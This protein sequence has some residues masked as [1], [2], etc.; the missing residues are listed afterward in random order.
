MIAI[1]SSRKVQHNDVVW[2][3]I[4]DPK[5][6]QYTIDA[7]LLFCEQRPEGPSANLCALLDHSCVRWASVQSIEALVAHLES[8][9]PAFTLSGDIPCDASVFAHFTRCWL[10]IVRGSREPQTLCE[11]VIKQEF[12]IKRRRWPIQIMQPTHTE[13]Q[14]LLKTWGS[15]AAHVQM[16]NIYLRGLGCTFETLRGF[17]KWITPGSIEDFCEYLNYRRTLHLSCF[18]KERVTVGFEKIKSALIDAVSGNCLKLERVSNA[19]TG[20]ELI[21]A[22]ALLPLIGRH[23]THVILCLFPVCDACSIINRRGV[24]TDACVVGPGAASA[25]QKAIKQK[26]TLKSIAIEHNPLKLYTDDVQHCLCH[27]GKFVRFLGRQCV[28]T[29]PRVN[30]RS[31]RPSALHLSHTIEQHSHANEAGCFALTRTVFVMIVGPPGS[32]KTTIVQN[33]IRKNSFVARVEGQLAWLENAS[34]IILGRWKCFHVDTKLAGHMDGTDRIHASAIPALS[35]KVQ[36]FVANGKPLIIA[37]GLRLL[38]SKFLSTLESLDCDVVLFSLDTDQNLARHRVFAR[39]GN[40][41]PRLQR[42]VDRWTKRFHNMKV[43]A[44]QRFSCV[45]ATPETVVQAVEHLFTRAGAS[46]DTNIPPS[47]CALPQPPPGWTLRRE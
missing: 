32:G 38:N 23:R 21:Q 8:P 24:W 20:A 36:T 29:A 17:G 6:H 31:A 15:P 2:F 27:F 30:Y 3:S 33:L 4:D 43:I 41:C 40:C 42:Q 9:P 19:K 37:E 10:D 25:L 16:L 46:T 5:L 47:P 22:L 44:K 18:E 7:T 34:S 26:K 28:H 39:E 13:L 35:Q 1:I 11:R 45:D 12:V 14:N